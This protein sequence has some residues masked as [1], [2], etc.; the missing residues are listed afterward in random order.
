MQQSAADSSTLAVLKSAFT[1]RADQKCAH[2]LVLQLLH[3]AA[4][5]VAAT[6]AELSSQEPCAA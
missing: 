5:S 1:S 2:R 6:M 3:T 4:D